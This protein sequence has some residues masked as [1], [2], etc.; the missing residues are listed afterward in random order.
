MPDEV[1]IG[2][3]RARQR[4]PEAGKMGSAVPLRNVVREAEDAFVIAVVPP[5][6]RLSTV[7]IAFRVSPSL[8]E[9]RLGQKAACARG[10][11][12]ARTLLGLL[13]IGT[14]S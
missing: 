8:D 9:N 10:R 7:L 5:Q 1:A 6:R 2:V 13:H 4:G 14:R 11:G 3:D 12:I